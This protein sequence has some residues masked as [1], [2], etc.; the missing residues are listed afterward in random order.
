M[1]WKDKIVLVTGHTGFKGSWLCIYL[2]ELGAKVIGYS[3]DSKNEKDNYNL[4]NLKDR[5]I[6]IKGDIR[7]FNKLSEVF[8][9][10]NPDI[11]F[12][13]AAQP[14][15]IESYKNPHETYETNVMGT[16]NVLEGMKTISKK[17]VGIIITTDK[18]YENKEQLWGYRENDTLGGYDL[19]SSSKACCEILVNSYRN[20]FFNEDKYN[21]H[22]KSISTVRAGNVIGGGDWSEH[23]LI[24]DFIK[25]F[26]SNE[27]VIIRSPKSIRPWQHVIEPLNGYLLLAEKTYE[28]PLKFAGAYNFGPDT[29]EIM[30]VESLGNKISKYLGTN[31]LIKIEEDNS[32]YETKLLLLD[33]SK[34]KIELGWRPVL[35]TDEVINFTI[36]WY[37]NY[38]Y[39]DVY[40]I[41]KKQIQEYTFI[42]EKRM[43]IFN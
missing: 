38:I 27:K 18:C 31:N 25:A 10:Y 6:D 17:S 11:V 24:P 35:K 12:H 42:K 13:L 34:S 33:N 32:F 40:E 29:N 37:K 8:K 41:C 28:N 36:D 2:L 43:N 26:E 39:E 7:D 20:S 19:Y 30:T 1:F 4:S 9:K 3:L 5:I 14:L 23:R 22:Q 15:V 16:L 21:E